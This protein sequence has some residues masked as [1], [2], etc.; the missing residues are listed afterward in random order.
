V[1]GTLAVVTP[2]SVFFLFDSVLKIRFPR[3]LLIDW[4]Y[5]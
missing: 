4:Y 1:A 3:G 5:G 2:L